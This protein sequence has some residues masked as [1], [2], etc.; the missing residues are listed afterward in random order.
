MGREVKLTREGYER[1]Q[2]QLET[3]QARL[4]E[5]TRILREQM[6]SSDDYDDTGLEDAKREKAGIE[7]RID[8][9]EDTISRAVIIEVP[10]GGDAVALGSCVTLKE[11]KSGKELHVQLVSGAEAS[12]LG[13]GIMKVSDDSPLG[14]QLVGRRVHDIFVVNLER[15]Q[16][17]YRVLSID[18]PS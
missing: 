15:G 16:L 5:A 6:E 2:R 1:L 18:H 7:A 9:L 10:D 12:I 13:S 3:E 4:A 11:E 14:K 8:E 17:K